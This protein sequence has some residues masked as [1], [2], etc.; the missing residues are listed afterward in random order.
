MLV[1]SLFQS[2]RDNRTLPF[3]NQFYVISYKMNIK[4]S[5]NVNVLECYQEL[6]HDYG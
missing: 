4:L 6:K 1:D 2:L 3:I 5:K